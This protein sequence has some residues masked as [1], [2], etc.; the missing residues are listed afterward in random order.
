M[1]MPEIATISSDL[2]ATLKHADCLTN[3]RCSLDPRLDQLIVYSS[4]LEHLLQQKL[5][6]EKEHDT[7]LRRLERFRCDG[8]K[9]YRI[10]VQLRV[11]NKVQSML[12]N[13]VFKMR[14]EYDKF[15]RF[16]LQEVSIKDVDTELYNR[17]WQ[18]LNTCR[19][20]LRLTH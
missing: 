8:V 2:A 13:I 7:E 12:P 10:K 14:N 18:L 6:Y 4:V 9:E 11:I 1:F 17:G 16:L 19:N 20:N 15:E 3:L 5:H